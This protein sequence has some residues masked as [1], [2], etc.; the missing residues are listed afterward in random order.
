MGKRKTTES[1][2]KTAFLPAF[3]LTPTVVSVLYI[4]RL[5]RTLTLFITTNGIYCCVLLCSSIG[6][7][8]TKKIHEYYVLARTH[9]NFN[10][11]FPFWFSQHFPRTRHTLI[12]H[13]GNSSI[14]QL[15]L[16][17]WKFPWIIYLT[18]FDLLNKNVMRTTKNKL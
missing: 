9:A 7:K 18:A 3:C 14:K 1:C 6:Q 16:Q 12:W 5:A 2:R 15:K 17:W 11:L 13:F 10:L 4:V 8:H